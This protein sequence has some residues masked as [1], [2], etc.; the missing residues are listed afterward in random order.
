MALFSETPAEASYDS[1]TQTERDYEGIT[2]SLNDYIDNFLSGNDST[3]YKGAYQ[4]MIDSLDSQNE[5]IDE[6]IVRLDKYL[7]S[8]EKDSKRWLY[9]NG[10]NAVKNGHSNANLAKYL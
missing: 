4:A 2:F 3:G 7:E 1:I 9:E 8:R 6:K 5:R 10:R